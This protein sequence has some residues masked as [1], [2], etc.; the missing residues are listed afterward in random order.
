MLCTVLRRRTCTNME[1]LASR[2]VTLQRSMGSRSE[3][4]M[5]AVC[6]TGTA[7]PRCSMV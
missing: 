3:V 4:Q 1:G 6:G 2:V 7:R 5:A